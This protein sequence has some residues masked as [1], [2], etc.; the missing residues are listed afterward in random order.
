MH[1][2]APSLSMLYELVGILFTAVNVV[3]LIGGRDKIVGNEL[4]VLKYLALAT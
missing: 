1:L 3:L 4:L 2:T